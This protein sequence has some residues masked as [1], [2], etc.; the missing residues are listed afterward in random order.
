MM[1]HNEEVDAESTIFTE[2][3]NSLAEKIM[4]NFQYT[5]SYLSENYEGEIN[6][7]LSL[8]ENY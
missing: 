2:G 6:D 7:I 4:Y 1:S 3:I 8:D 5:L